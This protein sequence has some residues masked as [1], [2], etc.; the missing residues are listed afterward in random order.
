VNGNVSASGRKI[1]SKD[2][3]TLTITVNSAPHVR[4]DDRH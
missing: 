3:Q 4:I 2:G 1:V